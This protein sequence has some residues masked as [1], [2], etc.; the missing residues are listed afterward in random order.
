MPT[1]RK[2]PSRIRPSPLALRWREAMPPSN[3][4]SV[5]PGA[6]EKFF[7]EPGQS[8]ISPIFLKKRNAKFLFKL[9]DGMA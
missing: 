6:G 9:S 1:G 3:V 7:A 5:W 4:A 2:N 8:G